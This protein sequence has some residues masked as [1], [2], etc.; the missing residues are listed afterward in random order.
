MSFKRA[1]I[2][3]SFA[4]DEQLL[5]DLIGIGFL[6]QGSGTQNPNIENTVVAA[7][8]AGMSGDIRV[9]SLLVDWLE[10]HSSR[11]LLDR[12]TKL[13]ASVSDRR[14]RAFWSAV[15]KW[16]AT[17]SRFKRI[18]KIYRGPRIDLLSSGT[19]FHL[20]RHGEDP[21]FL[22]S[23]LRVPAKA[24]LRHRPNDVLD[25][26]ALARIHRAYHYRVVIG[27]TYRADMWAELELA[28]ESSPSE[29]AKRC[30]G[31]FATAWNVKNEF[32]IVQVAA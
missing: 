3:E 6:L 18:A 28:P 22:H 15:G 32:G 13:V 9:L 26:A 31:S 19:A 7:S 29:L 17:D 8:I 11:L 10:I 21:R 12:L 5:A 2:P 14:V 27:A 16:K 23:P 20:Q 1:I 30:Y 4:A 25:P 24:G